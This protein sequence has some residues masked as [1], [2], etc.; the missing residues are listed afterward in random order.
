MHPNTREEGG[1]DRGWYIAGQL[2]RRRVPRAGRRDPHL[3][4]PPVQALVADRLASAASGEQPVRS[5]GNECARPATVGHRRGRRPGRRRSG[6]GVRRARRLA[7]ESDR[8][9]VWPSWTV[10][11]S[12]RSTAR[13][14]SGWHVLVVQEP[15]GQLPVQ[16]ARHEC[17]W[18]R[19]PGGGRG[20]VPVVRAEK[21]TDMADLC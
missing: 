20:R 10:T 14:R 17:R 19:P 11:S 7:A 21:S 16:V 2:E 13:R 1:H 5:F 18:A 9:V 4:Q 12:R 3:A 6:R 8:I 15:S